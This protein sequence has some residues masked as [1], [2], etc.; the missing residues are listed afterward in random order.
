MKLLCMYEY[1]HVHDNVND[2]E[3]F[4]QTQKGILM[5]IIFILQDFPKN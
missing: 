1:V 5:K 4:R 2:D 3:K